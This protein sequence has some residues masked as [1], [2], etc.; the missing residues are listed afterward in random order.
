M[1]REEAASWAEDP[2]ED[3]HLFGLGSSISI[4]EWTA[5]ASFL[6]YLYVSVTAYPAMTD[7]RLALVKD[8]APATA[9]A[10]KGAAPLLAA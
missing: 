4:L 9:A 6:V 8:S 10:K 2:I 3:P 1:P 5:W 7:V